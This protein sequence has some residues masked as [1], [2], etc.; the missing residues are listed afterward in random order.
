M[1][2]DPASNSPA[3]MD[4]IVFNRAFLTG[5][6]HAYMAQA[7]ANGQLSGD[8]PFTRRSERQLEAMTGSVRALLTHSCTG[9]LEMA[10]MLLD[11]Q[12]GDEVIMPSFTFVSTANAFVLRGAVPVFV[13]ARADT[14]NID[15]TQI[16]AAITPRTRAIVV[17]HYA[18]VACEMGPI[19]AIASRHGLSVIEDA[20]QALLSTYRD[21][22]LGSFGGLATLSF[23]ETKNV[24]CGEGG[25]LLINDPALVARSEILREK[26]TDRAKFIRNEVDRYTWVDVGSSYLPGELAAAFLLAQLEHAERITERRRA[27]WH[28]YYEALGDLEHDGLL[29]RPVVPKGCYA[30]AHLFYVLLAHADQRAGVLDRLRAEGV[31]AVFHY[32]PLHSSPAGMRHGRAHGALPVTDEIA[33]RLIRLPLWVGVEPHQ[34]RVVD[35]LIA[36]VRGAGRAP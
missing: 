4:P 29:R 21:R 14:C 20:A 17:V 12:A 11:L 6:E 32:V 13:D 26:G 2:P 28:R 33:S 27:V 36:A 31:Q 16:E 24:T 22:P 25:A 5:G 15:E 35:A 8:G 3:P 23:H 1:N 30:N 7:C 18:G 9:A 34:P 19:C 10:A